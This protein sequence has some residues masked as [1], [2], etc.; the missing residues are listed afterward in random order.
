MEKGWLKQDT[1]LLSRLANL[2]L[3]EVFLQEY[4]QLLQKLPLFTHVQDLVQQS[5]ILDFDNLNRPG[6]LVSN[7]EHKDAINCSRVLF[8]L[9]L[10]PSFPNNGLQT[11]N[12][13]LSAKS[14]VLFIIL[15]LNSI[16]AFLYTLSI[17]NILVRSS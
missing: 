14:K 16:R 11:S 12:F 4:L 8:T 3:N 2:N 7:I 13:F 10:K 15:I 1:E 9:L 17:L 5:P 6:T